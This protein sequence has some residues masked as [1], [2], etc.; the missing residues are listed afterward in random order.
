MLGVLA[1]LAPQPTRA[2][3]AVLQQ[4][5]AYDDYG[6]LARLLGRQAVDQTRERL[7]E[8]T[9]QYLVDALYTEFQAAPIETPVP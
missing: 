7:R 1:L 8:L 9:D 2:H 5:Y 3:L 6:M 4:E